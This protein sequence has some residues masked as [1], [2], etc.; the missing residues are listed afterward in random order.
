[1]KITFELS[2]EEFW[3]K[4]RVIVRE[5]LEDLY[6]ATEQEKT[7]AARNSTITALEPEV[8]DNARYSLS[9]TCKILNLSIKTVLKYTE[10]GAIKCGIRKSNGRKFYT[11]TDI[12][13]FWKAQ[14]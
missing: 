7:Q 6:N 5:E 12:K 8:V 9:E 10:Q 14:Y 11:G 1:M 3:S 4:L 13:K 2:E